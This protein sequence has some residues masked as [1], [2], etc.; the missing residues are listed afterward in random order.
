MRPKSPWGTV[1]YAVSL[2]ST[3]AAALR[4]PR[5][6][7]VVV[8]EEQ[9]Q[10][11]GRLGRDWTTIPSS[12]LAVSVVVP[13]AREGLLG[14]VPLMAGLAVRDAVGTAAGL[15]VALKWPND[16]IVPSDD[17][18]KL[19]GI[20]CQWAP[21]VGVVIG[22][23]INVLTPRSALPVDTATSV[24]AAGGRVTR[25]ALLTAFLDA[26]A[27][28]HGELGDHPER[29]RGA[30]RACC[31]TIGRQVQVHEPARERV[32][33]VLGVDDEGRL[34]L[35]TAQGAVALSAGDVVH[36]RPARPS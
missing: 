4:D 8:A 23:G 24:V 25:E 34:L 16:V 10:G 1:E 30:Y 29:T 14:W 27:R 26:L 18:R 21:G 35:A 22:V 15:D 13:L 33:R 5:P 3:N 31:A 11:R 28:R 9:V 6:W 32:G 36:V 17:D 20:L 2:D 12:A 19:A 7:R